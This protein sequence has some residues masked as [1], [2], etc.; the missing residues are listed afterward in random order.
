MTDANATANRDYIKDAITLV[1]LLNAGHANDAQ[2]LLDRYESS[3]DKS[4]LA[5]MLA[6]V[7]MSLAVYVDKMAYD[8]S[9]VKPGYPVTSSADVL[10]RLENVMAEAAGN[11]ASDNSSRAEPISYL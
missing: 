10:T 6:T 9:A 7:A 8:L 5:G 4:G 1:K 11:N 2:I 3:D